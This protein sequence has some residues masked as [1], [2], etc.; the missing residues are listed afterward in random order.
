MRRVTLLTRGDCDLCVH[1]KRVLERLAPE[2]GLA[3]EE[4]SLETP[5]GQELAASSGTAFPPGLL[6]DGRPFSYGRLSER[7]LRRE[8]GRLASDTESFPL[9]DG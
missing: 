5:R 2:Y 9:R 7:T 6:L 1:A 8:L 4:V 3:V